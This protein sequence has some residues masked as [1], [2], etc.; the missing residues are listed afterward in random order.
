MIKDISGGGKK[1]SNK[2]DEHEEYM[3]EQMERKF[4]LCN[5][6]VAKKSLARGA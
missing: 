3:L 5:E 6:K 1:I 4:K 2:I